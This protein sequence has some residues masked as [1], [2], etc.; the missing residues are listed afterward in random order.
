MSHRFFVQLASLRCQI[1]SSYIVV[2]PLRPCCPTL[3]SIFF[4]N[5][6]LLD[7]QIYSILIVRWPLVC[8][9]HGTSVGFPLRDSFG[10]VAEW[11]VL[12]SSVTLLAYC[13]DILS[14]LANLLVCMCFSDGSLPRPLVMLRCGLALFLSLVS[15][16]LS[17]VSFPLFLHSFFSPTFSH[18]W[19]LPR[20]RPCVFFYIFLHLFLSPILFVVLLL[21]SHMSAGFCCFLP[22]L[23]PIFA[24]L[25]G[26]CFSWG[27]CL[28]YTVCRLHLMVYWVFHCLFYSA[29]C[30][31]NSLFVRIYLAGHVAHFFVHIFPW[32]H[33]H[34][35]V[36]SL[37]LV[38]PA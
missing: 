37:A 6:S 18:P 34:L 15:V 14:F 28:S 29:R 22:P 7:T 9:P 10:S 33:A 26:F 24:N 38:P 35:R 12:P 11:F 31:C 23:S 19:F 4:A 13:P 1:V 36:R 5:T 2:L 30:R 27:C 3:Y 16:S 25:L 20:T 21:A 17:Y 8:H 32:H